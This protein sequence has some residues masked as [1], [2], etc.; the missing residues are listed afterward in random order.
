MYAL[1]LKKKKKQVD[2]LDPPSDYRYIT[3]AESIHK[4]KVGGTYKKSLHSHFNI[5]TRMSSQHKSGLD[6]LL[7]FTKFLPLISTPGQEVVD[8]AG[9]V[10]ITSTYHHFCAQTI[11][12]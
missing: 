4:L 12:S 2:L 5:D 8:S 11:S 9:K 6:S 7:A 3:Y 1:A 10:G